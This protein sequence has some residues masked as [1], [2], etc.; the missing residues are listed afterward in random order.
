MGSG[1]R[2]KPQKRAVR[3]KFIERH[4][5][6]VFDDFEKPSE[7]VHDGKQGPQ[8]TTSRVEL[9]E[10]LPGHGKHYCIPCSKYF[11]SENALETHQKSKPHKRRLGE[12]VKVQSSGEKPHTARD[13]ERAA[14]MGAPDNGPTLRSRKAVPMTDS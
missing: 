5:D 14:G 8:G 7:D 2:R 13:A 12:L 1:N 6:Q 11:I 9:D 3:G 4:I 10:D